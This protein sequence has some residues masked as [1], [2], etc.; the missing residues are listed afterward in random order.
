MLLLVSRTGLFRLTECLKVCQACI[1]WPSTSGCE[2][3]VNCFGKR[4]INV[5]ERTACELVAQQRTSR[6]SAH[7]TTAAGDISHSAIAGQGNCS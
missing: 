2:V 3:H 6:C 1:G 4:Y 7:A 5:Y